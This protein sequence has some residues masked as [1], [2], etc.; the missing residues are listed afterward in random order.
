MSQCIAYHAS[1]GPTLRLKRCKGR[2]EKDAQFCRSHILAICGGY[3]GLC[4]SSVPEGASGKS[5]PTSPKVD[6]SKLQ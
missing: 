5:S 4:V 1:T 3:L 2:A 6:R